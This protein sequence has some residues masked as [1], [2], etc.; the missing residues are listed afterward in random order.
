MGRTKNGVV[1]VGWHVQRCGIHCVPGLCLEKRCD[2]SMSLVSLPDNEAGRN[3]EG[4]APSVWWSA[5]RRGTSV[6]TVRRHHAAVRV[7]RRSHCAVRIGVGQ[8]HG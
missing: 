4:N 8:S 5:V 2:P 6:R 3:H 1:R 7:A